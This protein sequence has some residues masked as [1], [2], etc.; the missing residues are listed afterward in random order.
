[1][2]TLFITLALLTAPYWGS[3]IE[4]A[5]NLG[6]ITKAIGNGDVT[7]LVSYMD[8]EVELSILNDED[9][10]SRDQARQKL[11]AFFG[12]NKPTGFNQV[13]QGA[14]K[15]DDAEYLIGNLATTTGDFRVYIYVAKRGG[16]MVLQE[17]RF[18][19]E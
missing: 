18:E 8:A 7:G 9:L 10:Y 2:K 17:L 4:G 12:Q 15:A 11:T 16:A 1:M 14:S 6:E 19:K 5:N 3:G 13:H